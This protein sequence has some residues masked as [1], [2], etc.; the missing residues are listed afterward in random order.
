MVQRSNV[1][2]YFTPRVD[3]NVE[4]EIGLGWSNPKDRHDTPYKDEAPHFFETTCELELGLRRHFCSTC[5]REAAYLLCGGVLSRVRLRYEGVSPRMGI[6]CALLLGGLAPLSSGIGRLHLPVGRL[7]LHHVRYP[8]CVPAD[9][10]RWTRCTL[11]TLKHS[12][13]A[14]C[15]HPSHALTY[16]RLPLLLHG[17][18]VLLLMV[19]VRSASVSRLGLAH[20]CLSICCARRKIRP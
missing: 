18:S 3:F 17:T 7:Y 14:R 15:R 8:C 1:A 4:I 2:A 13:T 12:A 11:S 10:I 20:P 19:F 6:T 16:L 9:W 5:W